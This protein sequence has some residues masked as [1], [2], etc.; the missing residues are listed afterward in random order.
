M[1][2]AQ[3]LLEQ[4]SDRM[5]AILAKEPDPQL[6]MSQILREAESAGLIDASG[7]IRTR[8]PALFAMDLLTDNPTALEWAGN[9]REWLKPLR[10]G[11]LPSLLAAL[12]P[13]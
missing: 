8:T 7:A 11:D 5:Q 6:A 12:R 4:L 3:K 13:A 10:I 9:V 1:I 2:D